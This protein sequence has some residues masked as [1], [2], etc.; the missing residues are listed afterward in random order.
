V[1]A[2]QFDV[3][4]LRESMYHVRLGKVKTVLEHC[5]KYLKPSGVLIVPTS[6]ETTK[7]RPK[8]RLRISEREFEVIEKSHYGESPDTMAVVF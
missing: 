4:L 1:P 5:A 7:H 8:S 3:I 2:Q 6:G